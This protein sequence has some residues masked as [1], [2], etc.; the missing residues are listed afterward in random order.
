MSAITDNGELKQCSICRRVYACG[1]YS[2]T[3]EDKT[4]TLSKMEYPSVCPNCC[5]L[6]MRTLT[7]QEY[8]GRSTRGQTIS[9]DRPV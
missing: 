3:I 2:I 4:D 9:D 5:A 1:G 6:I 8:E 7:I